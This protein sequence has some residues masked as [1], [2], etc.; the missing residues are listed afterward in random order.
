MT[1]KN[2]LFGLFLIPAL[3]FAQQKGDSKIIVVASDTTNLLN[4]IAITF[5][6]KGYSIEGKDPAI[7]YVA[8][9]E[10]T[11]KTV[12]ASTKVRAIVKDSTIVFTGLCALDIKILDSE[13]TF[14]PTSYKTNKGNIFRTAWDE[15]YF[16]A[17]QFGTRISFSK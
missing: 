1:M 11:M 9:G 8:S 14:Y 12:A 4:R 13:R 17:K 5:I 6:D 2:I 7:G 15:M 3:S 16:I 10:K